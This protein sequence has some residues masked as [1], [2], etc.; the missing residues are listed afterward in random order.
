MIFLRKTKTGRSENRFSDEQQLISLA[1]GGDEDACEEI[2]KRNKDR[3]FS[4]CY[5][6]SGNFH[7]AE[8]ILQESFLKAFRSLGQFRN[9]SS[10]AT[11]L[12]RVAVNTSLAHLRQRRRDNDLFSEMTD[13]TEDRESESEGS[14]CEV[15]NRSWKILDLERAVSELP[16]GYRVVF[17]LH[18][19]EGWE[20]QEIAGLL[21]CSE[22]TSKSQLSKARLKMRKLLKG[23]GKRQEETDSASNQSL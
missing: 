21:E 3:L 7:T 12:Y 15:Q 11:W 17:V 20:H 13:E 22:G 6:L 9:D 4:V 18:D 2:F 19:V 8:D 14:G 16:E 5:R 10:L 1:I 23:Y